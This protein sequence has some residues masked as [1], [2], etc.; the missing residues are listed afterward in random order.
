MKK[1]VWIFVA[2]M[3]V[4]LA[5]CACE[6]TGET[7]K[8]EPD[9]KIEETVGEDISASDESDNRYHE[10]QELTATEFELDPNTMLRIDI[11]EAGL[12]NIYIRD[13]IEFI[14]IDKET[15][16][17][18]YLFADDRFGGYM[19]TSN[20]YLAAEIR[21]RM[22]IKDIA[23]WDNQCSMFSEMDSCDIDGDGDEEIVLQEGIDLTGGAGQYLSRIFDFSDGDF[24]EIF[25]SVISD[26][27]DDFDT[28]FRSEILPG[29]KLRII[30]EF[31]GYD[32][33]FEGKW[34]DSNEAYETWWYDEEGNPQERELM[35]DSFCEFVPE[36]V[37]GDGVYEIKCSQYT[38]LVGHSD[39]KG[40]AVSVLKYNNS[41][42]RFEV[43]D[44]HFEPY[45]EK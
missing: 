10:H 3:A 36:D 17:K 14:E 29:R 38:S 25:S 15:Y 40:M 35:V 27:F 9:E 26:D 12:E 30:N 33:V 39:H 45:F 7:E 16:A 32:E 37:D 41:K 44:A 20:L 2:M 1:W 28:G 11:P 31:T 42:H 4:M 19:S 18:V 13:I 5:L 34:Y 23:K 6:T 24:K 8:I 22:I 21:D 43:V